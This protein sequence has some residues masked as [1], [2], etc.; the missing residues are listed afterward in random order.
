MPRNYKKEYAN[1]QGRPEQIKR[2]SNRNKARRE[3]IK[4]GIITPRAP[5]DIDHKNSNPMDNR[6][7]NLRPLVARQNRSFPRTRT[8]REK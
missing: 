8:A 2:R 5:V 3:A 7:S 6:L 4:A 1:Y